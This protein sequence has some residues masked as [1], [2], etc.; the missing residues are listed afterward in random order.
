MADKYCVP[1]NLV[2]TKEKL[3]PSGKFKLIIGSYKTKDGHGQKWWNY[4]KGTIIRL[5]DNKVIQEICRNYS[6]FHHGFFVRNGMEWFWSG[7]TYLSQLFINLETEHIYE[8]SNNTNEFCWSK[9]KISPDGNTL[10]V[11][12]CVWGGSYEYNFYDFSN[13]EKGWPLLNFDSYN[14]D[15][16]LC[17]SDDTNA[18]WLLDNTFEFIDNKQF[19]PKF[20]KYEYELTSEEFEQLPEDEYDK[21]FFKEEQ[22]RIILERKNTEIYFKKITST[23]KYEESLKTLKENQIKIHK[24]INDIKE[25]NSKFKSIITAFP[26]KKFYVAHFYQDN[27]FFSLNKP[28]EEAHFILSTTDDQNKLSFKIYSDKVLINNTEFKTVREAIDYIK[29]K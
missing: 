9:V 17:D 22:Y 29:S 18:D 19:C 21:C 6:T 26:E 8:N 5:S 12:G 4:T 1:E 25:N 7:R 28:I 13:P 15:Y 3:S 24:F 27:S 23:D 16:G 11:C 2:N 10:A 20:N 14:L